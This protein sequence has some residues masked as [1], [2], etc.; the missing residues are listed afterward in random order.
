MKFQKG[1][2]VVIKSDT[3]SRLG[4]SPETF[5]GFVGIV[6]ALPTEIAGGGHYGINFGR[7]IFKGFLFDGSKIC[8][9]HSLG[10]RLKR[11]Y[12][13]FVHED[14]LEFFDVENIFPEA[15]EGDE[16]GIEDLI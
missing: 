8:V 10:G 4:G 7:R 15:Q 12:G 9:T 16:S 6:V 1:D 14:D 3:K 11:P 13:Q 5:L 2:K